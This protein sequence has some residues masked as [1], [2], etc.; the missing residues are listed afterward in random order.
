MLM[1]LILSLNVFQ[2]EADTVKKRGKHILE[3]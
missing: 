2:I 3:L 1:L